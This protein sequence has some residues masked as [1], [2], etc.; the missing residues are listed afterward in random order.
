MFCCISGLDA[1]ACFVWGVSVLGDLQS[2]GRKFFAIKTIKVLASVKATFYL[3]LKGER[4]LF[5]FLTQ[6]FLKSV[7]IKRETFQCLTNYNALAI[8]TEYLGVFGVFYLQVDES[9]E[10]LICC[11]LANLSH[12][13]HFCFICFYRSVSWL[14]L[15]TAKIMSFQWM[16]VLKPFRGS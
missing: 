13:L 1:V 3:V 16:M 15:P 10:V 9:G 8:Q 2:C 4:S 12:S 6:S 11:L 7:R 14:E 5:W